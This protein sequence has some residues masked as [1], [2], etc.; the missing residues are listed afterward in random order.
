MNKK[1]YTWKDLESTAEHVALSMYRDMW[2]PDYIVGITRGGLPLATVLSHK[3]SVPVVALGVSLRDSELGCETNCW[4]SEWAF[5]YNYPEETSISGARW[6]PKLRKN[7]LVVDDINDTGAT[8]NWIKQD[9]QSSCFP[10]ETE[11]WNAV[12]H[13]SVR[14]AV[15]TD[16]LSSTANVDYSWDEVN[17][18]EED[19]WL[20]FPWEG[21]R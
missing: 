8:I 5:G 15:M 19:V 4:L 17:K 3:I 14:F 7:I 11:V 13:K 6:D 16:N 9:W 12:W 18:A 10:K 21:Q 1:Y 2:R 20:V